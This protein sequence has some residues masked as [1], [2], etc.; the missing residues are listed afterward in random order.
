MRQ[1][2]ELVTYV[3]RVQVPSRSMF[4][5]LT[6]RLRSKE[7]DLCQTSQLSPQLQP[8]TDQTTHIVDS[9]SFSLS[10]CNAPVW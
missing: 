10:R 9:A 5:I 6:F 8:N 3:V 2:Q 1:F 7:K 4:F